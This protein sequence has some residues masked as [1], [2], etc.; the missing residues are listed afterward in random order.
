MR[1]MKR[2]II[3]LFV[4][5]A[6]FTIAV[7]PI[8]AAQNSSLPPW[9]I[10][11]IKPIQDSINS[12]FQR[13]DNHEARIAE[14][15]KKKGEDFNIPNQWNVSF[16][17]E[18]NGKDTIIMQAPQ[19][20]GLFIILPNNKPYCNWNGAFIGNEVSARAIAH[21]STGNIYGAGSC[22]AIEFQS[23][24]NPLESRSSFEV[25]IYLWWQGVEKYTKQTITVPDRPFPPRSSFLVNPSSNGLSIQGTGTIGIGTTSATERLIIDCGIYNCSDLLKINN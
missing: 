16:Y 3:L 15:E 5:L 18:Q 8:Y 1:I 9:F 6:F 10:E 22:K 25:E 23:I 11:V 21:L 7:S 14:L 4:A 17:Q 20:S 13:I 2:K 19:P 12:L 24:E